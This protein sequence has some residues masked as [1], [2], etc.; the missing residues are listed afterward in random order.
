ML[1]ILSHMWTIAILFIGALQICNILIMLTLKKTD[2][3]TYRLLVKVTRDHFGCRNEV[4]S[5]LMGI[6][7]VV[8][9][10]PLVVV[11][12]TLDESILQQI[13]FFMVVV[14]STFIILNYDNLYDDKL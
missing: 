13:A 7:G 6:T 5:K 1:S 3:P 4:I 11:M 12:Y 2:I 8:V 9:L 14:A 10:M